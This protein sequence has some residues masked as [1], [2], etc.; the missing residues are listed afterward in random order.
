MRALHRYPGDAN[1]LP[2][3]RIGDAGVF[4]QQPD[5]LLVQRVQSIQKHACH[6]RRK[7]CCHYSSDTPKCKY[8]ID[9]GNVYSYNGCK[10]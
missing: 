6:L 7:S 3:V 10:T 9:F 5:D 4:N 2:D 8:K 1:L